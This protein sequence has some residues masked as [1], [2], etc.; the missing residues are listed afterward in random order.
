MVG[1]GRSHCKL[2][3]DTE[4]DELIKY[5]CVQLLCL[6]SFVYN[7]NTV[8]SVNEI[9]SLIKFAVCSSVSLP[10]YY[11]YLSMKGF[12]TEILMNI[13]TVCSMFENLSITTIKYVLQMF[14]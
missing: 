5:N 8:T 10:L 9:L 11:I 14:V 12:K 4:S 1:G 2:F 6:L 13:D 3:K 7:Q